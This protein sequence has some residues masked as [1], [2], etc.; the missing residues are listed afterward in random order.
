MAHSR[1]GLLHCTCPLLGVKRIFLAP[2]RHSGSRRSRIA[3]SCPLSGVKSGI[4]AH[5]AAAATNGFL[6][7]YVWQAFIR[8]ACGGGFR[9]CVQNGGEAL[10]QY[11]RRAELRWKFRSTDAPQGADWKAD[12]HPTIFAA[13]QTNRRRA[14]KLDKRRFRSIRSCSV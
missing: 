2:K 5:F 7:C 13:F 11:A 4:V 12:G 14:P 10:P 9:L 8:G 6:L 1:H 3:I